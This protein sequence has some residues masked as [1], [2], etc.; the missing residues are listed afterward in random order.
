[1][2]IIEN[3]TTGGQSIAVSQGSGADVTIANGASK[4][5]FTDGLGSGGAVYDGLD[6]IA[7]SANTTIGGST[8]ASQLAN[9]ITAS[10][11]TT[12]TNKTLAR[13]YGNNI[14]NI[15]NAQIEMCNCCFSRIS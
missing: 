7:L 13:W 2:F 5:V 8:L 4:I 9:F 10:S 14:P 11:T 12:L 15:K 6:K 3:A 1:M